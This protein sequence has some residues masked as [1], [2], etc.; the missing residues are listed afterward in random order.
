MVDMSV[1][2]GSDPQS[3]AIQLGKALNDP[4]QGVT[5]LS[6]VG[7][8]FT[9]QQKEQI[10]TLVA[11]GKTM[12]AQKV[13]LRELNVQFGGAAKAA[14][15]GFQGALFRAKDALS[16][17]FRDV[18]T[19]LLPGFTA[20]VERLSGY[21]TNTATP[22][23]LDFVKGFQDETGAGGRFRDKLTEVWEA[24]KDVGSALQ[25]GYE[26][27]KQI[28][29]FMGRHE[30]EVKTFGVAVGLYATAMK[31]AATW[32][33]AMAAINLGKLALGIGAVGTAS[34]TA[35][36]GVGALTA[37]GGVSGA[38]AAAK[39]AARKAGIAG[40]VGTVGGYVD[41][42]YIDAQGRYKDTKH[43]DGS[44]TRFD[45]KTG[46]VTT[47]KGPDVPLGTRGP[48][49]GRARGGPVSPGQAYRVGEYGPEVFVPQTAGR[50]VNREQQAAV[51]GG[52]GIVVN[53]HIEF[54]GYTGGP[55]DAD[56][57]VTIVR[58]GVRQE[59]ARR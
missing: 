4:A 15:S 47:I 44:I 26:K 12:D 28:V 14:G 33:S 49:G 40:V 30:Q 42:K 11:S 43:P 52:G 5:A 55:H 41:S 24:A 16:D 17:L 39:G 9:R 20:N 34:G 56:R 22:A 21:L 27:T 19:P 10:K 31:A 50:I 2:M 37:A 32:T 54:H 23:I 57:L 18:A 7:V 35:A 45:G 58:Q 46:K 29:D 8:S 3:A 36:G 25:T 1:A 13:I 59:L 6:K 38:A 53:Q 48:E 51:S